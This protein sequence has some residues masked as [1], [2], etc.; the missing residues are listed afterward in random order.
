MNLAARW[1]PILLFAAGCAAQTR[2]SAHPTPAAPAA[3]KAEANADTD[4]DAEGAVEETAQSPKE[5]LD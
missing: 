2:E 3:P 1:I 4:A 5:Q